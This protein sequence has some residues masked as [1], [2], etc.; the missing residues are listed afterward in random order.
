MRIVR[1][2][3][4]ATVLSL[5]TVIFVWIKRERRQVG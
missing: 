5:G 4:A 2:A 3:G 1:L